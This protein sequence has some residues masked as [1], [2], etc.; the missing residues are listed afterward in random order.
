MAARARFRDD[1]PGPVT[2]R[3]GLL[4]GEKSLLH[5]YLAVPFAGRAGLRL[6]SGPGPRALAGV[7]ILVG[8]NANPGFGAVRRLLQRD[9]EVVAQVGSAV[10]RGAAAARLVEDV[11]EDIA[12]C[13]GEARES[14]AG[15]RHARLRIDS[16]V[17]VTVVGGALVGVGQ[18]LVRLFC[19]LEKLFGLRV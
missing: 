1:F 12:E 8:R 6:R 3:A 2:F 4:D 7:A 17:P 13:V 11:A 9:L 19:F 15:A 10:Y 14:R 18:D 16:G 5:S